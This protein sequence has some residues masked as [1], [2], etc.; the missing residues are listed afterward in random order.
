MC[1]GLSFILF[2]YGQIVYIT[3]NYGRSIPSFSAALWMYF[4]TYK[5]LI[6]VSIKLENLKDKERRGKCE[7]RG[8]EGISYLCIGS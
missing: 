7:G 5:R 2:A 8:K 3:M 6:L 1:K 4:L